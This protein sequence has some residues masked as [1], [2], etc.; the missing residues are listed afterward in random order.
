MDYY[1]AFSVVGLSGVFM[2]MFGNDYK[3]EKRFKTKLNGIGSMFLGRFLRFPCHFNI[4]GIVSLVLLL[5]QTA[6]SALFVH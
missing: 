1:L 5:Q 6:S 2:N 3:E 4:S